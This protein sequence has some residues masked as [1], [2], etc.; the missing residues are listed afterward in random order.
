MTDLEARADRVRAVVEGNHGRVIKREG[1]VIEIEVPADIAIGL[2]SIWG[3]GGFSC[4][5]VGQR[6]RISHCRVIDMNGHTVVGHQMLTTVFYRFAV[7]L[8]VDTR[9]SNAQPTLAEITAPRKP[10][11][12]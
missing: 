7:D 6:T 1:I 8:T 12:G 4:I 10:F 5:Y 9:S 11:V 2:N 3:E